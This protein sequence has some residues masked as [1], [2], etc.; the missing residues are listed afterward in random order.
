M[1]EY[2]KQNLLRQRV[3]SEVL[4]AMNMKSVFFWVVM[5]C[6]SETAHVSEE[7]IASIIRSKSK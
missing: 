4:I 2:I 1:P 3:G 7:H 5:M 6:T